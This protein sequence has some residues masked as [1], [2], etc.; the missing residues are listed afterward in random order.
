MY[1]KINA[2][3]IFFYYFSKTY[4]SI[5]KKSIYCTNIKIDNVFL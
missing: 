4:D 5:F 3:L 2:S 1:E